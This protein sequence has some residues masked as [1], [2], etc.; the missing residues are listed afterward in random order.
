MRA[1]RARGTSWIRAILAIAGIGCG[2]ACATPLPPPLEAGRQ[3][4]LEDA[5]RGLPGV[6]DPAEARTLAQA[7]F[8]A[9]ASLASRYRPL[10][11]PHVG[12]LAFHLGLRER[13]LCC[14]WVEDLLRALD[15]V[16]LRDYE[17]HWVVAHHGSRLREHSAVLALPVGGSPSQGL[18]LDAWRDSGRLHWV[19]AD[20]D[21]YPWR[22][23]P[24]D[25]RRDRLRCG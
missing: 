1:R 8:A 15:G 23:H 19:R 13:A 5:L 2:L 6:S 3:A 24:A 14:H 16:E 22:L 20:A 9:T 17:L 12:N 7:A 4:Q 10:R 25:A 21:R 18:V 11:P